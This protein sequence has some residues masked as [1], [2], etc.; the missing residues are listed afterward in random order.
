MTFTAEITGHNATLFRSNPV[1][2]GHKN[3]NRIQ[4]LLN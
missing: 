2:T 3:K 1:G 4:V